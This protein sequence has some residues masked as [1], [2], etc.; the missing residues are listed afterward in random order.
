MDIQA[1]RVFLG[2]CRHL[3]FGKTS[4]EFHMSPSALSRL[5]QRLEASAGCP[6]LI[7]DNR[8]VELTEQGQQ[9]RSYASEVVAGWDELKRNM[10]QV[11]ERLS[12]SL[13]LF[14]SVTASQS[15]LPNVLSRFRENFPDI[16]I[17]LETGYAID[18]LQRLSEGADVVVAALSVDD[19]A[20][21]L[22]KIVTSTPIVGVASCD[23]ASSLGRSPNWEGV[24]LV[25]PGFGP[26]RDQV[27]DWVR[28]E[29]FKPEIYSEVDGNEAILSLVALGCGV[30]FVPQLVW[31]NSSLRD[32]IEVVAT[33]PFGEFHVGF[34]TRPRQLEKSA[35]IRAFWSSIEVVRP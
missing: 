12:G 11:D 8:S 18:A 3:H 14:A 25:L 26:V 30:G 29:G 15:I 27:D 4:A 21:L 34:C 2:L 31:E 23:M 10:Q 20:S 22:K 16:H 24:P 33:G 19:D 35:I 17:Q 5:V 6:L 13:R 28:S 7:R 32:R 1:L 9:L